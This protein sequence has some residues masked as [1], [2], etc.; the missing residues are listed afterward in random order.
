MIKEACKGWGGG[1]GGEGKSVN[2]R[3]SGRVCGGKVGGIATRG[4]KKSEPGRV[5]TR[6]GLGSRVGECYRREGVLS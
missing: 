2:V 4:S 1:V 5:D 3:R 6:G